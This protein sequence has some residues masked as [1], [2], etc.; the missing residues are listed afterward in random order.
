MTGK[1]KVSTKDTLP[2][3]VATRVHQAAEFLSSH[4]ITVLREQGNSS[5]EADILI[6]VIEMG[7][8]SHEHIKPFLLT[9][10]PKERQIKGITAVLR[11]P[12]DNKQFEI[13]YD[14]GECVDWFR[15][16]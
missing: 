4:G 5:L 8:I 11:D 7:D 1:L 9:V 16:E 10:F 2:D 12:E 13:P 14:L 6:E 15:I 3:E